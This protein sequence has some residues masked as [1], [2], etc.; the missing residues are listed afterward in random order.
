MLSQVHARETSAARSP[1]AHLSTARASTRSSRTSSASSSRASRTGTIPAS[2]PTSRSPAAVPASSRSSCRPRSTCRRCSGARRR[3]RPSSKRSRSAWLR[4]L[5]G[6]PSEFEGVIY[7]TASVSTLHA[8]AAAREAVVP[9]VR[10]AGLAGRSDLPRIP[11]LLLG[12]RALVGR[13]GGHPARPRTRR[14]RRR[15]PADA[16][17][18][19]RPDALAAAIARDRRAGVAPLAIV[20]TVGTTSTTSVD[21]VAAIAAIART[22][23]GLAARRRRL[24]GRRRDAPGSPAGS[25]AAPSA[26]IRSSS[27]P[28]KWLF[29]PFDLSVLYC[30]R[31]DTLRTAFSLTP[32]YL[33]DSRSRA[34][35]GT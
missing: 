9:D 27:I 11:R 12:A 25:C 15:S 20:A 35:A 5:I 10:R 31:M 14:R 6:L 26:P 34:G 32:E 8:L 23:A 19:M 29:T 24:R 22:R 30:R 3:R 2:S 1:R 18:R 4:Q 33:Q 7:D 13:Q 21:P 17:F 28:H 16:E